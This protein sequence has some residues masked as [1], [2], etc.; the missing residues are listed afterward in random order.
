MGGNE[1]EAQQRCK[2]VHVGLELDIVMVL[3]EMFHQ[4]LNM[5]V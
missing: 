1:A 2:H 4:N 5:L 3:Q